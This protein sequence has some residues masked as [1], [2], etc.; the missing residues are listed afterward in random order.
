MQVSGA[1]KESSIFKGKLYSGIERS[2]EAQ[3]KYP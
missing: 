2:Y 3:T 1:N